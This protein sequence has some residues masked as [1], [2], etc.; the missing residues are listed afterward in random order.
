MM[1][2]SVMLP[3]NRIRASIYYLTVNQVNQNITIHVLAN[4]AISFSNTKKTILLAV[5]IKTV[6]INSSAVPGGHTTPL[7][8]FT[9]IRHYA[10]QN[11]LIL[12][13]FGSGSILDLHPLSSPEMY[14]QNSI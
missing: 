1:N 13:L 12:Q 9:S 5:S 14:A 7:V 6:V 10:Q 4:M 2:P 3:M 8:P 11:K